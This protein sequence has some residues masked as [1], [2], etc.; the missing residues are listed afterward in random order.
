MHQI[1][2]PAQNDKTMAMVSWILCALT[3]F[4]GPLII[5]AIKKDQSKFVAFHAMQGVFLGL[6][7]I[8]LSLLTFG[9]GSI[10]TLIL[11]IVW[12]IMASQGNIAPLPLIGGWVANICGLKEEIASLKTGQPRLR[13]YYNVAVA[14][15]LTL[16]LVFIIARFIENANTNYPTADQ[17]AR[18][19]SQE[20]G[21]SAVPY[22]IGI[23]EIDG[24]RCERYKWVRE[25]GVQ[26]RNDGSATLPQRQEIAIDTLCLNNDGTFTRE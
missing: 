23:I 15:V 7:G 21:P 1:E 11:S 13:I 3:G 25:L 14:A 20:L 17:Y 24:R 16:L 22:L 5:W 4:L 12:S 10:I 18:G 19:R 6:V 2:P 9:L 8:V 26:W